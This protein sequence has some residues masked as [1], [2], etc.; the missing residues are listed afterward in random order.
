MKREVKER[1]PEEIAAMTEVNRRQY[2]LV[3][4]IV[5]SMCTVIWGVLLVLDM[6]HGAATLQLALHILCTILTAMAAVMNFIR[7]R[8]ATAPAES[9]EPSEESVVDD[10]LDSDN[11]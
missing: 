3:S 2:T 4:S 5:W 8:K 9:A 10:T 11:I 6:I 1:T 7:W